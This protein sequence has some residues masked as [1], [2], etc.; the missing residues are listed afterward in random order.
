MS[1][2]AKYPGM[3]QNSAWIKPIQ[4][5][6]GDIE[7][8]KTWYVA[9]KLDEFVRGLE[10]IIELYCADKE[11]YS[12]LTTEGQ[13]L[14]TLRDLAESSLDM[15]EKLRDMPDRVHAKLYKQADDIEAAKKALRMIWF[16]A[17]QLVAKAEPPKGGRTPHY[18]E[19]NAAKSLKVLFDSHGLQWSNNTWDGRTTPAI[20]ALELIFLY[21][22]SQKKRDAIATLIK[23]AGK[24]PVKK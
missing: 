19:N 14:A 13:D 4:L 15:M 8:I 17:T 10:R 3:A 7:E 20:E 11:I 12:T 23:N 9:D 16:N 24:K 18:A 1:A 2:K 6:Q 22:D 5:H 21:G